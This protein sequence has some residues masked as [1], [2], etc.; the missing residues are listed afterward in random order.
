VVWSLV[1]LAL[2]RLVQLIVLLGKSERSKELE[3]WCS[4]MS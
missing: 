3:T 2:C 1:Y 4:G